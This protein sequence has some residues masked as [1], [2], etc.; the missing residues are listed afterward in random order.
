MP[1][2]TS[3]VIEDG[4]VGIGGSAFSN[5]RGLTS[6]TIPKDVT[7]IGNHAFYCCSGLTSI[8]VKE[9]NSVYTSANGANAIIEKASKTLI[10]GCKNTIIPEGVTSIAGSAFSGC[11]GLTSI[12]IPNSVT[13]I[14]ESAFWGCTRLTDVMVKKNTPIDIYGTVFP[15]RSNATLYVPKGSRDAYMAADYWK[16]FKEII[17]SDH[18]P[19]KVDLLKS[20]GADVT[21][22]WDT[23]ELSIGLNNQSTDLT[24][25][26]FD[27]T[28]PEGFTLAKNDKG[29]F[30]VTLSDRY[31]DDEQSLTITQ[32]SNGSY[33]FI[34]Y[35]NSN[36]RITGTSG[37]LLS[38]TLSVES[39][40]PIGTY[41]A[42]VTDAR[43]TNTDKTAVWLRDLNIA[44]NVNEV[45]KGD[46]NNDGDINVADLVEII[47]Y[48][49]EHPSSRFFYAAADYNNDD[50]VDVT[51]VVC[52]VDYIMTPEPKDLIDL[53]KW[54]AT[55]AGGIP[56]GFI[57]NF[58][59]S[60][61]TSEDT[62]GSGPRMFGF[63]EGGDFTKGLYFREGDVVYGSVEG[64]ELPLEAGKKYVICFKSAMWKESGTQMTFQIMRK[65][66]PE[67]ALFSQ[68][69]DNAPNV[70][71]S[72]GPVSG[73][74]NTEI[75][76][77]P[78]FDG[79]YLLKWAVNGFVEVLLANST[80]KY[81][82]V[83]GIEETRPAEI[84][85]ADGRLVR[86]PAITTDGLPKD[87][88]IINGK[89]QILK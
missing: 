40:K 15:N 87:I 32:L 63:A 58:I 72:T 67:N 16:E 78:K 34:C 12:T 48:I 88:F 71:G 85:S 6:V 49:M 79:N 76:F 56:E 64:F 28:L 13:S 35:S 70:N 60:E 21:F 1:S 24:A 3:I 41:T 7:S 66:D 86:S 73:A 84:Y 8:V 69:I 22:G 30:K 14:E 55:L 50:I 23:S 74:T 52:V 65:D 19:S 37:P 17:E 29:R 54:E 45:L 33:R 11:S 61:R 26:Q 39:G 89:K 57:V 81:F 83:L 31:E 20:S 27:L 10:A 44:L 68:V 51:D 5:C 25:Y 36:G 62:Y 18:I 38:M 4:T 82:P 53:E 2:N 42:T 59:D 77:V 9:G 47:N 43:A 46:A 75:T 80:V